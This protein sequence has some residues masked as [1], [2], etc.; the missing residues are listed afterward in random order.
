M[1]DI[2]IIGDYHIIKEIGKGS[3]GK[4]YLV[5]KSG[6]EYIIK[7]P[8]EDI[9]EDLSQNEIRN[10]QYIKKECNPYLICIEDVINNNNIVLDF[11][12]NSIELHTYIKNRKK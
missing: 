3:Y 6:K 5:E 7:V 10:L 4:V 9:K 11:V 1:T 8:I 12:K 2:K